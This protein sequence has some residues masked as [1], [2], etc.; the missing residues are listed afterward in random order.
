[1]C[2][3][4]PDGLSFSYKCQ[5]AE[6]VGGQ[7]NADGRM[8]G[9]TAAAGGRTHGRV[10]SRRRR[11]ECSRWSQTKERLMN[12]KRAHGT[13][14]VKLT[15]NENQ[16]KRSESE[17]TVWVKEWTTDTSLWPQDY[18][19]LG[20]SCDPPSLLVLVSDQDPHLASAAQGQLLWARDWFIHT[21]ITLLLHRGMTNSES[22]DQ[23]LIIDSLWWTEMNLWRL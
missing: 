7:R 23:C 15:E 9:Q 16:N 17:K 4:S 8:D 11:K 6:P 2:W 22:T 3:V 13:I 18:R 5:E 20:S 12:H 21:S 14:C 1:M 10:I 19:G